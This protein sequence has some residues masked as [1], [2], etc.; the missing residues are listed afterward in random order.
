MSRAVLS[1][2]ML[3]TDR[4]R[5]RGRDLV[6]VVR[7]AVR[8]GVRLVQVREPD[9]RDDELHDLARR[10]RDACP[11]EISLVVNGSPRVARALGVGLH[12]PAAAPARGD[13]DLAGQPYGRSIHDEGEMRTA[14][15]DGADYLVLGTV[16]SSESK[17]GRPAGGL[18]L[19]ERIC[20]QVHPT[21][22]YAIGGITVT[23]VPPV[24][25]AG[26]FGVAVSGEILA[27][28]DP[29][30]VAEALHLALSVAL[31]SRS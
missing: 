1:K 14:L 18:A 3:V 25:H 12:L 19:V 8:G 30:R 16:F 20:R 22:V 21:P 11:A 27:A 5:T 26:A 2:L 10:L 17:P 29:C 4:H 28:S 31:V 15:R 6:R 13:V 7:E 23:R 9:L 24:V